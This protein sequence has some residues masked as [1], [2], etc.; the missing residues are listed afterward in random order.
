[1]ENQIYAQKLLMLC[2]QLVRSVQ[3]IELTTPKCMIATRQESM[4]YTFN[5][6]ATEMHANDATTFGKFRKYHYR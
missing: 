6:L 3:L 2:V 4:L 1:M 5:I